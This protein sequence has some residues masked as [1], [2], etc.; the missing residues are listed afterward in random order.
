MLLRI[1]IRVRRFSVQLWSNG[2]HNES[3]MYFN[4]SV[5]SNNILQKPE[6]LITNLYILTAFSR[7]SSL[8]INFW[9]FSLDPSTVFK[10]IFSMDSYSVI[11]FSR[12]IC[13]SRWLSCFSWDFTPSSSCCCSRFRFCSCSFSFLT[14][15]FPLSC[16]ISLI[17]LS[18]SRSCDFGCCSFVIL[19]WF[20][21]SCN[22]CRV[23]CDFEVLWFWLVWFSLWSLNFEID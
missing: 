18:I 6:F 9:D 2:H 12:F 17:I 23:C 7:F 22:C 19:S 16:F 1:R 3:F 10:T 21:I 20:L 8:T 5:F 13:S 4:I 11:S 14:C 15:S